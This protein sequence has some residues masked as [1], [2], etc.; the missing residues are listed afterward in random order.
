MT[1]TKTLTQ[2]A[3]LYKT[4]KGYDNGS[5]HNFAEVYDQYLNPFRE[6]YLNILEIGIWDGGSLNMW[7][8]YFPNA[9]IHGLDIEDKSFYN[10]D[11]IKCSIVDQSST[12]SLQSFAAAHSEG[13]YD[14]IIDDGSHHMRDQQITLAYLLPLLKSGGTY[15]LEDLHTSVC[16]S[17]T[18]LYGRPIVIEPDKS[19]TTLAFLQKKPYSSVYLSN[20]QNQRL[21]SA[22]SSCTIHK[23]PHNNQ[24]PWGLES[25]TSIITKK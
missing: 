11:R 5:G 14:L 10:T 9:K 23:I 13:Y 16:E 8:D 19:N 21:Q 12:D 17:G 25:I 15:I 18:M 3:N 7:A 4:D 22:I 20:E 24:G 6:T 2:L 1:T